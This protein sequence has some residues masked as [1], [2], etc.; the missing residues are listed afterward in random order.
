M[1]A[2]CT[3]GSQVREAMGVSMIAELTWLPVIVATISDAGSRKKSR[4]I[5]AVDS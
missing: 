4:F 5:C 1:T 3:V 2:F